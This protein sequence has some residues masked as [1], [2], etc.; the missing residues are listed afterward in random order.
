MLNAIHLELWKHKTICTIWDRN[1]SIERIT[2]ITIMSSKITGIRPGL[3]RAKSL[4]ADSIRSY[5]PINKII[6]KWLPCLCFAWHAALLKAVSPLSP[7]RQR[8]IN[9]IFHCTI[10]LISCWLKVSIDSHHKRVMITWCWLLNLDGVDFGTVYFI[11]YPVRFVTQK[12][13]QKNSMQ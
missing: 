9:V 11:A 8:F 4:F 3:K 5:Y 10:V 12:F 13:K 6:V 2:N 7:N 1:R